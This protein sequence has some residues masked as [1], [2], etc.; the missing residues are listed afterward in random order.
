MSENVSAPVGVRPPVVVV[1]RKRAVAVK[2]VAADAVELVSS[3]SYRSWISGLK[4]RYRATQIKAAIAVN[5][6][7]LEFYWNLGK[8]ISEKYAETQY[9][10][11]RFFEA[12]SKDLTDSIPNPKGLSVVN[13]RYCQR[14]YEFYRSERNLPQLVEELVKVPWG[15]HRLL[16]D[17]CKGDSRMAVFYVRETLANEWSR[18]QLEDAVES[19]LYSRKSKALDNFT[20]RLPEGEGR[21][22]RELVKSPYIFEFTETVDAENEREVEKALVHNITRT[23]TELGGGF[24][25]VGHQVRVPVGE[26]EFFPD[27]IF[28]HLALR[29][30]FVIELKARKFKPAD[31]G[32]LRFY[33]TCVD[34]QI[35]HEWDDPTVGLVLCKSRDKTVVEYALSDEDR[36]VGVA[37]YKLTKVPP[38]ELRIAAA[39]IARL[40]AVVDETYEESGTDERG[41]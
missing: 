28:Y 12:V 25:Y 40:T 20:E 9:Y 23:L 14:F 2:T 21:L 8:D 6:A 33:M 19:G 24:A 26:E 22:V 18:A 5:S 3:K 7:L 36:P 27:L 16:L 37:Q 30:Y 10:G 17:K 4:K 41:H 15:H 32:Q 34:R 1:K 39:S 35:K 29:R 31:L 13:I 38:E 11:S